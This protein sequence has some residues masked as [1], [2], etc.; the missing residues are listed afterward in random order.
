MQCEAEYR[1]RDASPTGAPAVSASAEVRLHRDLGLIDAVGIGFGAIVGAGIFVVSGIAAGIAGPAFLVALLIAAGAAACNGL[2]SAQLAAEYPHSGGTYEYGHIVLNPSLG[3]AAG[4][5]FLVSKL[6]AAGTV[7][8]GA[9]A[10]IYALAPDLNAR[11]VAVGAIVVFT[12]LNYFGVRRSSRA[13][14]V[15]VTLS[16]GALI[17]FII[18]A[19]GGV[20]AANFTPFAPAGTRAILQAAA[21]LFFA[22]TGYARIATLAEE[23]AEPRRT[24]PRAIHL[25]LGGAFLLYLAVGFVAVGTVGAGMLSATAAPLLVAAQAAQQGWLATVVGVGGV[26]AMLG[27]LLSQVLGLSR[28]VLAMAR[29]GDLPRA[30]G[31]VHPR[32]RTPSRAVLVIGAAAA[33]IA[34]LGALRDVAAA[35]AFAILIY[36]GIANVAALRMPATA[37]LYSNAVPVVGLAACVALAVS[38]PGA[39]IGTGILMLAAGFG[40]RAIFH[41]ISGS[42]RNDERS[43]RFG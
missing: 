25:T 20:R 30:L 22:Y 8:L 4:W 13:N 7:A 38:L 41:G 5:M 31:V 14:L 21:I 24:I 9:A 33:V 11:A 12:I 29:R 32:Y 18:G 26:A 17:T 10:Y 2:S 3:F 6:A 34:A 40:F 19:A 23:V 39:T 15:I 42:G 27:V 35:A 36:Y 37:K 28:M 16:V 1:P 43:G